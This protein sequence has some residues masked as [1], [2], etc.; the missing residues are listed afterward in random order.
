MGHAGP[1]SRVVIERLSRPPPPPFTQV[2]E[3][4]FRVRVSSSRFFFHGSFCRRKEFCCYHTDHSTQQNNN[5]VSRIKSVEICHHTYEG[6]VEEE[7]EIDRNHC[8][9]EFRIHL[10]AYALVLTPLAFLKLCAPIPPRG[11][12]NRFVRLRFGRVGW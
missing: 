11:A 2:F 10:G 8:E 4:A 1:S 3:F 6:H 12:I 5:T 9:Q 7:G